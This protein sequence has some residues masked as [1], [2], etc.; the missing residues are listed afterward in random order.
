MT[1]EMPTD[2]PA[3]A[4]EARRDRFLQRV[5]ARTYE[6]QHAQVPGGDDTKCV[7]DLHRLTAE[8]NAPRSSDQGDIQPVI[9]HE[10]RAGA[11][12]LDGKLP[13]ERKERVGAVRCEV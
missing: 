12:L 3:R 1:K 6:W 4:T 2:P 7:G 9:H 5:H 11:F 13:G 10:P 8:L